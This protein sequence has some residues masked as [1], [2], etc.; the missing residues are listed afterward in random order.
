MFA[1]PRGAACRDRGYQEQP[2]DRGLIDNFSH[3]RSA[4]PRNHPDIADMLRD[5]R[6]VTA[7]N[8]IKVRAKAP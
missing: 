5:R 1:V 3:H 4:W 2:T 7:I 8:D 6:L